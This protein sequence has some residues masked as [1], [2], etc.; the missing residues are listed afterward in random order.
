LIALTS[1][2]GPPPT[3]RTPLPKPVDEYMAA[4]SWLAEADCASARIASKGE[5][6]CSKNCPSRRAHPGLGAHLQVAD[7][8]QTTGTSYRNLSPAEHTMQRE[9]D[10]QVGLRDGGYLLA[11]VYRPQNP[12]RFP[13]L[14]ATSPYPRQIQDLGTPTAII[15]VGDSE[16]FVSRGHVHVIANL[17]GT[18]APPASRPSSTSRSTG[19]CSTGRQGRP[20][21]TRRRC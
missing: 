6:R 13:V 12:G 16:F 21:P 4:P 1:P 2:T 15:E 19:T 20:D 11:Y 7:G 10:R 5:P 3:T 9:V 18:V 17:R 14:I 8:H